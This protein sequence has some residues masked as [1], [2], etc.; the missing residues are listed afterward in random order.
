MLPMFLMPDEIIVNDKAK[1]GFTKFL[2]VVKFLL[3]DGDA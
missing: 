1:N 2:C 3:G